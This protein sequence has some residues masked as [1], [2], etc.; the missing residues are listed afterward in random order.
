[1]RDRILEVK[2]YIR[3]LPGSLGIVLDDRAN[4]AIWRNSNAHTEYPAAS[5]IKLAMITDLLLRNRA[6]S[7]H[8]TPADWA[9]IHG[10]LYT[11]NDNDAKDLWD[12]YE[13]AS[14]IDR[15]LAFGMTS[16]DF[17]NAVLGQHRHDTA[18]S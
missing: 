18:R 16:T 14:F 10:A 2:H 5:T 7:I 9:A 11:S 6:G 15:I 3:H 1:M 8:L 4:G 12:R 17:T 13:D